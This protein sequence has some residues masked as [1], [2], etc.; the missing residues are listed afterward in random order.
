MGGGLGSKTVGIS[1][2]IKD[3]PSKERTREQYRPSPEDEVR[4]RIEKIDSGCGSEVDFL[5]LKR[6]QEAL[7]QKKP[8]T[9]RIK[10]LMAMIEPVMKRFGYYF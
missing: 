1:V 4:K 6:L 8:C 5:V 3:T 2:I 7:R 9:P 10:N